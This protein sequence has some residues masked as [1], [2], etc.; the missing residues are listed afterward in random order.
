MWMFITTLCLRDGGILIFSGNELIFWR[1]NSPNS[2]MSWS[3]LWA[4]PSREIVILWHF[5]MRL[6]WKCVHAL[7]FGDFSKM[8]QHAKSQCPWDLYHKISAEPRSPFSE[9]FCQDLH[10]NNCK[11][12]FLARMPMFS[13]VFIPIW[14]LALGFLSIYFMIS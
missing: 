1:W 12:C 10:M 6:F 4:F 5:W 13:G 14:D 9:T 3:T 8:A 7:S 2:L 11:F